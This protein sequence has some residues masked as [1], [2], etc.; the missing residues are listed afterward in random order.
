MKYPN[1]HEFE[2]KALYPSQ[3]RF[4]P[5]Y[6]RELDAKRAAKIAAEFDGDIFNEPKV[7][8]RDGTYWCF[9][10]QHSIAAWKIL[11]NNRDK[12]V[13]CKVFK[14]MTWLD[15][16]EAF[17]K[18][19]GLNKDP[20]TNQKLRAAYNSKQPDV[21]A[22]VELAKTVGL[23]VDFSQSAM[24]NRILCTNALFRAYKALSSEAYTE[25][26]TVIKAAWNGDPDSLQ[27]PII[28]GMSTFYRFYYGNF[29]RDDFIKN[30]T[31]I[32]PNEIVRNG[33]TYTT[34]RNGYTRELVKV[35]NKGRRFRLDE[36]VMSS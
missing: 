9:N 12:M 5:L 24:Q 2:Q 35:Y 10:G 7:S 31:K 18:Q 16:C 13:L 14:G 6:Q 26:L 8:Y 3:I 29:K 4:D 23:I 19:N 21:V 27:R 22:M 30:L 25:M 20:T 17:M 34:Q 33:K 32:S 1:G 11:H 28:D 36:S 15:E